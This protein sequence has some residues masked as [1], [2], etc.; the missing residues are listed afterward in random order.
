MLDCSDCGGRN[1]LSPRS[2]Y[3][4]R[5]RDSTLSAS[6]YSRQACAGRFCPLAIWRTTSNL[7]SR[8]CIRF[9]IVSSPCLVCSLRH[10]GEVDFFHCPVLG[11]Q[12]N[13]TRTMSYFSPTK[14][15]YIDATFG[16]IVPSWDALDTLFTQL[17]PSWAPSGRSYPVR[18][19][20]DTTSALIFYTDTPELFGHEIRTIGSVNFEQGKIVRWVDYWDGRHFGI[21]NVEQLRTPANQF[22]QDFKES[23]VGETA[24]PAMCVA[25]ANLAQ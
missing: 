12:S 14:L 18:I 23:T 1:A 16:W 11:V 25:V 7:N 10:F 15:T 6:P 5:Q 22:P 24:L 13:P 2:W 19:L 9:C 17:M 21:T 20:G 8:L 4:L 3:S